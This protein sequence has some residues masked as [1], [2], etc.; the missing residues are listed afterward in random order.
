MLIVDGRIFET[1][2][3]GSLATH[4][5]ETVAQKVDLRLDAFD[6]VGRGELPHIDDL[7]AGKYDVVMLTGSSGWSKR[8]CSP[9]AEAQ[10]TPHSRPRQSGSPA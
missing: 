6:L 5:D 1:W 10:N 2:L 4:P 3:S 7:R 8:F 9:C